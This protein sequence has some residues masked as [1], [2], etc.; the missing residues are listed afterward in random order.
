MEL[1]DMIVI[2]LAVFTLWLVVFLW[3]G[4][5]N[6][7]VKDAF[8]YTIIATFRS[9]VILRTVLKYLID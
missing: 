8:I 7:T 6:G 9:L 5:T 4:L 2:S 3:I 1:I